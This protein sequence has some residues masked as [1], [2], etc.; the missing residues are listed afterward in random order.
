MLLRH[1]TSAVILW[2]VVCFFAVPAMAQTSLAGQNVNMVSGTDWTTGDPFLQRQNEPSMAVSTRNNLHLLAGN[3]DYRTVDLP[4]LLGI[5]ENGDAWLGLFKSFDGGLTWSST[6]LPGYPLDSSMVG[7]ASP[8]HGYQ[9]ASDPTV[10]SGPAGLFYYS[11]IAFN[12]TPTNNALGAVFVARLIDNNNRENGDPMAKT[13]SGLTN[14]TPTDPIRYLGATVIGS[15]TAGQFLDKPW[16]AV[17]I[18]RNP[19]TCTVS[20]TNPDGTTGTQR[21]PAARVFIAWSNFTGTGGASKINVSY[22]DNCGASFPNSVKVSQANSINQGT[23]IAIDPSVPATSPATV[24]VAWR[25]FA[26]G[27]QS[28]AIVISKSTDGGASWGKTVD[29]IDFPI[30]CATNSTTPGCQFDQIGGGGR[31][32][33]NAYPALAVDATGR[34]YIAV[35]QRQANGD[36][37]VVLT[38]S[39]DGGNTWSA[40]APVDNGLVYDDSGNPLGSL[41]GRG[42]QIMP[43]LNFN[44]GKLSLI[45]YDLRQDHTIG[46]FN[47]AFDGGGNVTGYDELRELLDDLTNNPGSVFTAFI[48]DGTLTVRRHTMD[49]QGALADPPPAGGVTMPSF[50]TF[51]ISKYFVGYDPGSNQAEQL[52]VNPP[53]LPIFVKGT[54]AFMGDYID[55]AGAPPFLIQNGTWQ[56]NT[57]NSN[58]QVFHAVW[59]DNR[60]VVEPPNGDWSQYTPPYSLSNPT[61]PHLSVFDATQTTPQCDPNAS[62]YVGTR[63]QNIYTARIE[64]P[65]TATSPGNQ[66]PL[67]YQSGST[68]QMLQRAFPVNVRNA[69]NAPLNIRLTTSQPSGGSASFLQSASQATLDITVASHSTVARSLFA[70]SANTNDSFSMTAAQ[71]DAI[72]GNIVPNGLTSS[73]VFNPDPSAPQIINPDGLPSQDPPIAQGEVY[74]PVITPVIEPGT[75]TNITTPLTNPSVI[76]PYV[77]NPAIKTNPAVKTNYPVQNPA[78]KTNTALN[79]AVKTNTTLNTALDDPSIYNPSIASAANANQ[80]IADAIYEVTNTGNTAATY[81]VK[82]FN[83]DSTLSN[84]PRP[85]CQGTATTA[86]T[87]IQLL[88]AKQY[89][90]NTN[91]GCSLAVQNNF[92][93]YINVDP[94]FVTDPS[95][96]GDPI[97]NHSETSNATVALAPNETGFVILRTNLSPTELQQLVGAVAPV[98]VAHAANTGTANPP[99]TLAITTNALPGAIVNQSYS[100]SIGTFGGRSPYRFS[101]T[102]GSPPGGVQLNGTTGA[103]TGF[104]S[105]TGTYTFTVSVTDSSPVPNS[106]VRTFTMN[107]F[108]QLLITTTSLPG[109]IVG[110]PYSQS[111]LTS[112]GS[113]LNYTWSAT[114]LPSFLTIDPASGTITGQGGTPGTYSFNVSISDPGPPAQSAS[115][116]LSVNFTENT[117]VSVAASPNPALFGV[118]VAMSVTV[119]PTASGTAVPIGSVKVTD[120]TGASCTANLTNGSGSCSLTPLSLNASDTVTATFAGNNIFNGNS[121]TTSLAVNKGTTAVGL[122]L[123]PTAAVVGQQVQANVTVTPSGTVPISP[124]GKV[125]VSDGAGASCMAT[126]SVTTQGQPSSGSC[127]L[128]PSSSGTRTIQAGYA[129]DTSFLA[130]NGSASLA[131]TQA[132]TSTTVSSP[133]TTAVAGQTIT[134]NFLVGANAPSTGTPV[135]TGTV[136]V[137]NSTGGSCTGSLSNGAGS[138][139][140]V[141]GNTGTSAL[142]GTYSGDGSYSG[143]SSGQT[144]GPVVGKANSTTAISASPGTT[145]V[146]QPYTVNVTVAPA[147]SGLPSGTVTVSDGTSSC[148]ITSLS[149]GKGACQMSTTTAGSITLTASY[150]GDSNFNTSAGTAIQTVSPASTATAI[151]SVSPSPATIGQSVTASFAVAILAPGAG[152]AAGSVIVTDGTDASCVGTLIGGA[153]SCLTTPTSAGTRTLVASFASANGNYTGSTSSGVT[154]QVNK[155]NSTTTVTSSPNPT[156]LVQPVMVSVSVGGG[157]LTPMGSVSVSDTTGATC[158]MTLSGGKG[159]CSIT[160]KTVGTDTITATYLGD[161]NYNGSSGSVAQQK[162]LY[163]FTGFYTPLAPAGTYSGSF[164]FGKAL[165]IKWTLTDNNGNLITSLSS[166]SAV[167]AFFN[168]AQV[169]GTCPINPSGSSELLYSPTKGATGNS[170]F[171]YSSG[172]FILNWD[173]ATADSLGK[174]CFTLVLQLNDGSSEMTSM[175]IQ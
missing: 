25:R 63:N 21:V 43:A 97:I 123:S 149:S 143:S 167:Q 145:V 137:T 3:N 4:G 165:P 71:I 101:I 74:T 159:S 79:P 5:E 153:G 169:N 164:N 38:M 88:I 136:T 67:G 98:V 150:G 157:G 134:A 80:P 70:Q 24:Y 103:L 42:H 166:L 161:G 22:S 65:L 151:T 41:S 127:T 156:F 75:T 72:G 171:R 158:S 131:V 11:G 32:R 96:L 27:G 160:P 49:V 172:Q 140:L 52:T 10:R 45:Y 31:F 68:T 85:L 139:N 26:N 108:A 133:Q 129:G 99:A 138:C 13:G 155:A 15:G 77:Q 28:D 66:K 106:F 82:L 114:G 120:T 84:L 53:D 35:S 57:S 7:Q 126:L 168:G 29:V 37:R 163:K 110:S 130:S 92:V 124:S 122:T 19:N 154:L 135:P 20:F 51:R 54:A 9:A 89:L 95:Q 90:T 125:S 119:S 115:Q 76:S 107:I 55:L 30:S 56:F 62:D 162:V 104:P 117:T 6:L 113:G 73:I 173:T 152:T 148:M 46:I 81:V 132:S 105:N 94:T 83:S 78:I 91:V 2:L 128:L 44:A 16:L 112:G 87:Y 36:A 121:G 17:D 175:L 146:G 109:G 34:V 111:L 48:D 18:P 12:R 60:D 118:P 93:T 174:G 58:P 8:L 147:Y 144:Q 86:C 33:S 102:N 23:I 141:V 69:T 142:S 170:T 1:R 39:A 64:P 116:S 59:T 47:P 100:A 61:T 50:N 40:P 14:L